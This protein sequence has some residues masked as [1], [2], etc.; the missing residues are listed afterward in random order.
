M[1]LD[2]V[3]YT[4]TCESSSY[5]E[6]IATLNAETWLQA[7]RFEMDSI[8]VNDTWELVR[9]PTRRKSLPCKWVFKYKYVSGS[10]RP[11]FKALLIA[12][13]FKQDHDVEYDELFLS[14]IKMRT[15]WLL[16]RV[17]VIEDLELA[18]LD[19]KTMFLHEDLEEDIYMSQPTAF[20]VTKEEGHLICRLKNP[21]RLGARA[22]DVVP[23][24]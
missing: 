4:D 22:N 3:N 16:L 10:N 14:V 20:M 19:V 12:K 1:G 17:V 23:E 6:A 7:M 9:L 13:G 5:H 18:Q 21:L 11:K 2:Y 15:L 8:K 24:V